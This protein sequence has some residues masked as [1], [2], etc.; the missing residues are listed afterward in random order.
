M[1]FKS[2]KGYT[3]YTFEKIDLNG[4]PI[5]FLVFSLIIKVTNFVKIQIFFGYPFLFCNFTKMN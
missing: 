4:I 1:C 3:R 2:L 5:I